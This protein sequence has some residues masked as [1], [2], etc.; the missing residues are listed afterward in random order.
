MVRVE[1]VKTD[2]VSG[3]IERLEMTSWSQGGNKWWRR[4]RGRLLPVLFVEQCAER[5]TATWTDRKAKGKWL[6]FLQCSFWLLPITMAMAL[7]TILPP[8]QDKA[9]TWWQKTPAASTDNFA[10]TPHVGQLWGLEGSSFSQVNCNF[11]Q[12]SCSMN[13]GLEV[14]TGVSNDLMPFESSQ[15]EKD[16]LLWQETS[17]HSKLGLFYK[18]R[19]NLAQCSLLYFLHS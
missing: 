3:E 13:L 10:F 6:S 16:L 2:Q 19:S 1:I 12:A 11:T 17:L 5:W 14:D 15:K 7:P 9:P 8:L 18:N 4:E